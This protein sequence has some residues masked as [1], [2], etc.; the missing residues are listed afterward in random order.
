MHWCAVHDMCGVEWCVTYQ[1]MQFSK[2]ISIH[3]LHQIGNKIVRYS[4]QILVCI[5]CLCAIYT[6]ILNLYDKLPNPFHTDTRFCTRSHVSI[7]LYTVI[8]IQSPLSFSILILYIYSYV[9]ECYTTI[10]YTS[11]SCERVHISAM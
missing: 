8:Y 1:F 2:T 4:E 10:L 11:V 7:Y 9:C 6:R 3:Q 5:W